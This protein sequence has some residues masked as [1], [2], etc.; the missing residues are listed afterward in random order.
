MPGGG[1]VTLGI[2]WAKRCCC[3]WMAIAPCGANAGSAATLKLTRAA[4]ARQ[5]STVIRDGLGQSD[6]FILPPAV[7]D[8]GHRGAKPRNSTLAVRTASRVHPR[9]EQ[10]IDVQ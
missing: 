4:I 2:S 6:A 9:S 1:K 10:A 7:A 5:A 3:C 8:L